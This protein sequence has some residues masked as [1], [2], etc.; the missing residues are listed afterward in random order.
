MNKVNFFSKVFCPKCHFYFGLNTIAC[1]LHYKYTHNP[2]DLL[3]S[4]SILDNQQKIDITKSHSCPECKIQFKKLSDLNN[5]LN[6]TGHFPGPIK[7]KILVFM[8][9]FDDCGFHT[10]SFFPFKTHLVG[11]SYFNK[12]MYKFDEEPRVK[13]TVNIFPVPNKFFHISSFNENNAKQCAILIIN[14]AKALTFKTWTFLCTSEKVQNLIDKKI[15]W[16]SCRR[17]WRRAFTTWPSKHLSLLWWPTFSFLLRITGPET[18][19]INL[20]TPNRGLTFPC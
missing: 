2:D 4:L 13:V 16:I 12:P 18:A 3:Y 11:H 7:N 15:S 1:G 19:F 6:S 14:R 9:P 8:C 17:V 20:Q 10:S 5:H